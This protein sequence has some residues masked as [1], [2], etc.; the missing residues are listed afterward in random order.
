MSSFLNNLAARS[1]NLA[2][3]AQPR[4]A[5]RFETR[6]RSEA[7]DADLPFGEQSFETER[8]NDEQDVF[9]ARMLTNEPTLNDRQTLRIDRTARRPTARV[10][11]SEQ[12]ATDA[13]HSQVIRQEQ[14]NNSVRQAE[15]Q[16]QLN[17]TSSQLVARPPVLPIKTESQNSQTPSPEAERSLIE[18]FSTSAKESK[19]NDDEARRDSFMKEDESALERQIRRLVAEHLNAG[20][21][22]QENAAGNSNLSESHDVFQHAS[23]SAST[24]APTIR[25]T[26]GRIDVRAVTSPQSQ[27]TRTAP[28]RPAPQLSLADYL[29]QRSGGR[30]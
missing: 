1:L 6:P 21:G 18:K 7:F 25:V 27:Q 4:L 12:S 22:R 5:S 29:K 30:G 8:S 15:S 23:Q 17:P 3:L 9:D 19:S 10:N 28:V 26:I 24:Q 13:P 11:N 2:P 20:A 16:P 14:Q